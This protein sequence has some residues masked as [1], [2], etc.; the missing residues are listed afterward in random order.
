MLLLYDY[1]I[2]I[3]QDG[4]RIYQLDGDWILVKLEE[5]NKFSETETDDA[6]FVNYMLLTLYSRDD[7]KFDNL[8]KT[9][10]D[11]LESNYILHIYYRLYRPISKQI[12]AVNKNRM[13]FNF[14]CSSACKIS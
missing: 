5:L 6:V 8:S 12:K 2:N 4:N 7:I 3:L 13:P 9:K 11:F 14:K 1:S 10:M